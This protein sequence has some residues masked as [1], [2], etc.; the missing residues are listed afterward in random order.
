[1]KN[2]TE[3]F[4]TSFARVSDPILEQEFYATFYARF[5]LTHKDVAAMFSKTDMNHQFGMLHESLHELV[6]F[7]LT[8]VKTP[9]ILK[10]ASVHGTGGLGVI[11]KLYDYWL[12]ALMEAVAEMDPDFNADVETAWRVILAPGIAFMQ[13]DPK[14]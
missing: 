4:E 9:Y 2:Y 7:S 1:M 6:K 12:S 11:P 3:I 10:L 14:L 5:L 13:S 8:H